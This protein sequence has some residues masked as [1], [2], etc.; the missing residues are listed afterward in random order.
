MRSFVAVP[1]QTVRFIS[2]LGFC[3]DFSVE[4]AL[5]LSLSEAQAE[6]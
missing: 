2:W 5:D 6:Q 3:P 4:D 1:P